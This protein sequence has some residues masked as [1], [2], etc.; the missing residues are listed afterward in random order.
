MWRIRMWIIRITLLSWS[1]NTTLVA[2][3]KPIRALRQF[4]S[5][6]ASGGSL[7]CQT[8]NGYHR[9]QLDPDPSLCEQITV[10]QRSEPSW[11]AYCN[12]TLYARSP[13]IHGALAKLDTKT[14]KIKETTF[15]AGGA[16][17][18]SKVLN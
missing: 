16:H 6:A 3:S 11:L 17:Q 8:E 14:F 18:N 13:S 2:K 7:Y 10:E 15:M 4:C 9:V 5:I 1:R 12:N